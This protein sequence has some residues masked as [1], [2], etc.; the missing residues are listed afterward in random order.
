MR[1]GETAR[2]SGRRGRTLP[3]RAATQ[4]PWRPG[5]HQG[6]PQLHRA[7]GR[8]PRFG[9]QPP[10]NLFRPRP[11]PSHRWISRDCRELDQHLPVLRM[12]WP[13]SAS[14]YLRLSVGF[15]T[16]RGY[17]ICRAPNGATKAPIVHTPA[18]NTPVNRRRGAMP[19]RPPRRRS[20]IMTAP[21]S[22]RILDAGIWVRLAVAGLSGLL[23]LRAARLRASRAASAASFGGALGIRSS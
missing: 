19:W 11:T 13:S 20:R 4:R 17:A 15:H 22:Y 23:T 12:A 8:P 10:S 18:R 2:Q 9:G 14:R 7:T 3:V 1:P 21:S 5:R 6:S 16:A